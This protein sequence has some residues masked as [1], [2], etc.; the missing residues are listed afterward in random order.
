MLKKRVIASLVMAAIGIPAI[1][2]GGIYYLLL[3]GFFLIM[4]SWEYVK[5][6]QVAKF[7]P[8]MTV[9]VGGVFLLLVFRSYLPE[10]STALLALLVLLAMTVHLIAYERGQ[11]RAASD[12]ALTVCGFVYLG[13]LGAYLLD[14]RSLPGGLWWLLLTLG[15]VW[16]AD[17]AA[18]FIGS[19][20]GRHK[21]SPRL[22]PKKTWEGYWS[23][24]ILST[25]STAGLA[26]LFHNLTGL[27][28]TWWQGGFLG[29]VM[30]VFTTLGDLGESMLKRQAGL[31]DSSN[32]I[33]GHGGFLDRIDSWLW[34]ATIGYFLIS[35]M[36]I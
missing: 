24:V 36:F 13:W 2:F 20:F 17:S 8:S 34:A 10:F 23:G 3:I 29:L 22:S 32:I 15:S 4:A 35:W 26:I 7:T 18:F 11:D 9:T 25:L 16:I 12:F 6:F 33:P 30:S 1:I 31:K 5:I 19:R 14:V 27:Q 21:L 28:I